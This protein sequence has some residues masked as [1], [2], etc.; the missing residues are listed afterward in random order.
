[1]W[2]GDGLPS[3]RPSRKNEKKRRIEVTHFR[4]IT[5]FLAVCTVAALPAFAQSAAKKPV[6][7]SSTSSAASSSAKLFEK[8]TTV[9]GITE[10]HMPNGLK[11]LLFPDPSKPTV[12]VNITYLVGSRHEGYGETG[13]AH[14]LEHMNFKGTP[15]HPDISAEMRAHG[16][17]NN[18][19]TWF[20]RTNYFETVQATDEN[21]K[22]ALELEAD[23]MTHSNI[24]KKDLDSE[25][26]VVRN[27]FEMGENDPASILEERV[28]STAYLWHNYGHSTIG[29]RADIEN[30]PT[31]RLKNFYHYYYQPDNAVLL[32]AGKFDPDKTLQWIGQ[33]FGSIPRPARKLQNTYTLDPTQDGERSVTL[34]R[35]GDIQAVTVVYHGPAASHEDAVAVDVLSEILGDTPSGRLHKALVETK[36][37]TAVNAFEYELKEPG[38]IVIS[39]QLRADGPLDQVRDTML[40]VIENFNDTPPTKEEVER[41]KTSILKQIDLTLNNSDRIGLAFSEYIGSGDWRLF[42]LNR[43]RVRK[44]TPEDVA[45]VARTYLKTS[46]RTLGVF[47]PTKTPDRAEIP[48]VPDVAKLLEGY[49]GD[50]SVAQ[51]EAFDPSPSNIESRTKRGQ[52][53]NGMKWAVLSKK[54]RGNTVVASMTLRFGEEKSL[55]NQASI[56]E[57]AASML[58][59]GTS[60]HTRQQIADEFDRLKARVSVTGGPTQANISIET[61]AENFPAVLNLLAEVLRD[62]VFPASEFDQLK[63][64]S[65]ASVE[66]S[67]SDPQTMAITAM[68]RHQSD[69]PRGD[70]RYTPMPDEE[71]ADIKAATLD[72]VKN[73]YTQFYGANNGQLA[74]VGAVDVDQT[75]KL[76][77]DLFGNW[78]SA[79][80]FTRV[81][82]PYQEV[83]VSNESLEA[84]DKA[85][86]FFVAALNVKMRD[87]D[88][89]Y[90]AMV[91]GNYILGGGSGLESRL[92]T[93]IR[94]KE[95]LSYFVGSQFTAS[96]IDEAANFITF[97]IYAPQNVT[98]LEQAFREEVDRAL[99]DGFTDKEVAEA[100]GGWLQGRQV[101]RAQDAGLARTLSQDLFLNRT[102]AWDQQLEEKIKALTP[103]QIVEAMRR[104]IDPSKISIFKAGDFAKSTSPNPTPA[105]TN[106]PKP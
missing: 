95:G 41:A 10:Y 28:M 24:A 83:K 91:L 47:I 43:D 71:I 40:K 5:S 59:R 35:V 77:A 64:Q 21:L 7:K 48:A 44:V 90:P 105:P 96:P 11:V 79:S 23:R 31:E 42:F 97:A 13:M 102:L 1:M 32:V 12:T 66:E 51:G 22:W 81:A 94:Q 19:S 58:T 17:R 75:S 4:R 89:D 88:P 93:R 36:L 82:S 39:S 29:A 18:A 20:D 86:A 73:F 50:P 72:A 62:P 63:Q 54:T 98:K 57:L 74:I 101:S 26:T 61:T 33:Y 3:R 67:K 2:V 65:I 46:N 38:A 34:R 76:V 103:Q 99:K 37:A 85:N 27:E 55:M 16:A 6:A 30:V 69:Y 78:K 104:H 80:N 92:G 14:L 68:S 60:K 53:A 45:R 52:L 49:K 15:K 87:D 8:Y 100:K 70:V 84:P 9:E 56:A 25:M 106:P